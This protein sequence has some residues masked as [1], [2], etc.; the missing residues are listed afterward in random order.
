MK[1]FV[2]LFEALDRTTSTNEKVAALKAYFLAA[3]AE[4]AVWALYQLIGKKR[5][6]H[7]TSRT[8]RAIF[9]GF[10]QLPDWLF[11]ECYSHVGDSAE[12]ISLLLES[13][14]LPDANP[15]A[16]PF[17]LPPIELPLHR[18]LEEAIPLAAKLDDAAQAD[19]IC[20]WWQHLPPDHIFLLNKLLTGGFRV[21]VSQKLVV[22]ALAQAFDLEQGVIAHRLMGKWQPSSAFFEQLTDPADV[23]QD[24]SKPYPFFLASPIERKKLESDA[25]ESWQAALMRLGDPAAWQAEWKW[26]GIRAQAICRAGETFIWSR[27]EDVVSERFPELTE[28]L[29]NLPEGTVLDGEILA[30]RDGAPLSFALL[31]KRIGRLRPSKAILKQAPCVFM[32]YDLLEHAGQDLREQPLKQRREQLEDII[33]AADQPRLMCSSIVD[34]PDWSSLEDLRQ[35]SRERAVEG[36]MLKRRDSPYGVGRQRGDWWKFKVDPFTIDAVLLYA[37]AG[38]GRRSNLFTDYTFALWQGE[39]LVPFAKAYSGLS[40]KEIAELDRWIRRHTI[41]K[42]GPVRSVEPQ[43]VFE[44][45]F[46]GIAASKRHKSGVAVRF[47]RIHRWRRDKPAAEA[48]HL[49]DIKGLIL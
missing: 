48:N 35:S 10:T 31:Q 26:D 42:F 7:F 16:W 8:L 6:R 2:D 4:D 40:N 44:V 38:S 32:A 46:E 28:A 1:A 33:A 22:R 14:Q 47:P 17:D 20:H 30:F 23:A 15:K 24:A 43:L 9:Y 39:Q 37:Q 13:A 27:G 36:L 3:P 45:A 12:T 49:D 19:A 18:W 34:F 29:A 21:G 5:K 11:D 41:E 25:L